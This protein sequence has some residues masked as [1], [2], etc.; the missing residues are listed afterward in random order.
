MS[1]LVWLTFYSPLGRWVSSLRDHQTAGTVRK[2]SKGVET[3]EQADAGSAFPTAWG[4]RRVFGEST[5]RRGSRQLCYSFV[6]HPMASFKTG[7]G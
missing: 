4:I 1:G 2:N 3:R 7:F 6:A 5:S